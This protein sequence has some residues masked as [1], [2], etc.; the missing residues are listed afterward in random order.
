MNQNAAHLPYTI[1]KPKG[2]NK[3]WIRFSIKGQGQQRIPLN[4]YDEHEAQ[5]LA[6]AKYHE[7][8]GISNAGLSVS[9]KR[10]GAIAEEFIEE[11]EFAVAQEEKL[12]YQAKQY[13]PIIRT[14][15]VPYVAGKL[16]DKAISAVTAD[17]LDEYWK[18][19]KTYWSKGPGKNKSF[20]RYKRTKIVDGKP[21][22]TK[23]KR[24]VKEGPPAHSTLNKE[25]MLWRQF[26]RFCVRKKYALEMP[27][28]KLEK[29]KKRTVDAKPGFT[30]KEFLRLESVSKSRVDEAAEIKEY[31]RLHM[32][33]MKLHC[34]IMIA[35]YS[36]LR[37]TEL[38]NL[39]WGDI[40]E[41]E[42][43]LEEGL[44]YL[45]TVI[46]AGGKGKE[47]EMVPLPEV[48]IHLQ[49]LDQLFFLDMGREPDVNDPVF[50]KADGT[51]MKS[52]KKGLAS[53]LEAAGLRTTTDGKR[54][55]DSHS[56]RPFYISQQI[57]E[58]VNPHMLIRNTGT[59]GKMVNEHYNKILPTQ[60][61]G[62]LT[63]DW[64]KSR[65]LS[66]KKKK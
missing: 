20:I 1:F 43:E 9:R 61:I 5:T 58:G 56:F 64:L 24:P 62:S 17:D 8:R 12:A 47:R 7:T 23:L 31:G 55:R 18:W 57:R 42:V 65:F 27:P 25:A 46:Q 37:S 14:Y 39:R 33:R 28:I 48:I 32:D 54:M 44:K 36:G 63:P 13:P 60:E 2:S 50:A 10:I 11:I 15:F 19:R 53:L 16:K 41:R 40:D 34:F 21:K 51:P 59:T 49:T 35:G 3:W 30:L 29:S 26:F 6:V 38:N 4:T 66:R 45:T 22:T 52:F